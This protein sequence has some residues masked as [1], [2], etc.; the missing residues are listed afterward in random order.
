MGYLSTCGLDTN[1]P[2]SVLHPSFHPLSPP[3]SSSTDSQKGQTVETLVEGFFIPLAY[4]FILLRVDGYPIVFWGHLYGTKGPHAEPAACDGKLGDLA[5]ARHLYAYGELN[6]YWDNPNC[7]GW[8]R[9]GQ[10]GR[11]GGEA[12]FVRFFQ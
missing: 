7:I 5:L 12:A 9:R 8:V 10:C 1:L 6:D 11:C 3:L 4:A 2:F